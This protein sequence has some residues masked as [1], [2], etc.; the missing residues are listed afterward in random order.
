[1]FLAVDLVPAVRPRRDNLRWARELTAPATSFALVGI[2]PKASTWLYRRRHVAMA[3]ASGAR[4][5]HFAWGEG[6]RVSQQTTLRRGCCAANISARVASQ[7]RRPSIAF[8]FQLL[9]EGPTV[10]RENFSNVWLPE[11]DTNPN[12]VVESPARPQ[13]STLLTE[14]EDV[15][16]G[17]RWGGTS[18]F[19]DQLLAQ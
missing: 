10:N 6:D 19:N 11:C 4:P 16:S 12:T 15:E 1:V 13:F 17:H 18:I 9:G 2:L 5:S 3:E 14:A 8:D 7:S